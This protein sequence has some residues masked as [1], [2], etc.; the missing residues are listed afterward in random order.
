M[1][2]KGQLNDGTPLFTDTV[3]AAMGEDKLALGREIGRVWHLNLVIVSPKSAPWKA[4]VSSLT[5][6]RYRCT[7]FSRLCRRECVFTWE[8]HKC[9]SACDSILA[10]DQQLR[11]QQDSESR[12]SQPHG[13]SHLP[14]L[15]LQWGQRA[16]KGGP[17][18]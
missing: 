11:R 5:Q 8:F 3:L 2:L 12:T 4:A 1:E 18:F 17:F 10:A 15:L 16:G 14:L 7:C 9:A 13:H 6:M